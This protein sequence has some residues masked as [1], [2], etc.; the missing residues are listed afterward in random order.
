MFDF[1]IV[2]ILLCILVSFICVHIG[3]KVLFSALNEDLKD[4]D[5]I[6]NR[7]TTTN[8]TYNNC[9]VNNYTLN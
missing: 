1:N 2:P 8:I 5:V 7:G 6:D 3:L 4:D 9:T